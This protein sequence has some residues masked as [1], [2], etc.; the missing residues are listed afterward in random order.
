MIDPLLRSNEVKGSAE[1]VSSNHPSLDRSLLTAVG[2]S[3][4][5]GESSTDRNIWASWAKR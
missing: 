3:R 1:D 5:V 2:V 4:T